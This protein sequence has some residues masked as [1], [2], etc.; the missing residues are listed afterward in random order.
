MLAVIRRFIHIASLRFFLSRFAPEA[1]E[2]RS[3]AYY[4]RF[5]RRLQQDQLLV[6]GP[7]QYEF[8]PVV[9]DVVLQRLRLN[10]P[11]M[12]HESHRAALELYRGWMKAYPQD[13]GRFLLEVIYHDAASRASAREPGE[14]WGDEFW[15]LIGNWLSPQN[16]TFDQAYALYRGARDD[17]ELLRIMPPSLHE[18][19][20][21]RIKR[22][23]R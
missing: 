17:G 15:R 4:L 12:Y 13:C 3:D 18:A 2:G 23:L 19:L 22:L 16:L 9:R 7:D 20:L 6:G 10:R 11:E 5:L 8:V 21:E 14:A 1:R